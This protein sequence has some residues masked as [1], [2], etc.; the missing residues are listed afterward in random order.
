MKLNRRGSEHMKNGSF[1]GIE[2][3]N[4]FSSYR[5][6]ILDEQAGKIFHTLNL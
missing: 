1:I 5:I 6:K 3:K 2:H 4:A